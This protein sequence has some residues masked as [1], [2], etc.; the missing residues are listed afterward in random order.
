M[1]DSEIKRLKA[2]LKGLG[3]DFQQSPVYK[4]PSNLLP[5]INFKDT[6]DS[7]DILREPS[8][9]DKLNELAAKFK[10]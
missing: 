6:L 7:S 1:K 9:F 4:K 10:K 3:I 5:D 8:K 2:K